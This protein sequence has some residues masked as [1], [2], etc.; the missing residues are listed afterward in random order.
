MKDLFDRTKNGAMGS[1]LSLVVC[2]VRLFAPSGEP[3]TLEEKKRLLDC[4]R[5]IVA[6][7]LRFMLDVGTK[8]GNPSLQKRLESIRLF[9]AFLWL[10]QN[11]YL[12]S[13]CKIKRI[14]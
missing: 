8:N 3:K 1:D 9:F 7:I 10:I 14:A 12:P 13:S 11:L 2:V 4:S 5:K 6:I